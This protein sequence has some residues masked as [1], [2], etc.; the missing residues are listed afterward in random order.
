M[1]LDKLGSS[2]KETL[3]KIAKSMFVDESVVNELVKDIQRALLQADVN[4]KLV[5][6][7]SNSIKKRALEEKVPS[8]VTQKEY[9]VRIVYEELTKFMGG[10]KNEIVIDKTKKPFKIMMVG[11]FGSGKTTSISKI[12]RYY[13]N[14]GFKVATLGLDVHRPAAP[15]QLKQLSDRLNVT[16][17]I[18]EKEKNA[19]KIYK[20]YEKEFSKYD[21]LIIDTA[22]RDALSDDLIKELKELTNYAKPDE[23][24]LVI[25]SDLGQTA[26]K[27]AESFH[28]TCAV[29]GIFI[30]KLDGTAKGGGALSAC[31]ATQA[32][33]KFIGV[34]EKPE[35]I[36][37]FNPK[38]FVGRLL[39]MGDIEALLEKAQE[40]MDKETAEDL[41]K[42]L[43]KGEFNF[44]D[45][46]EQMSAMSKMGPLSKVMEMIPGMGG[47]KIPKEMLEG[48]EGKLKKWKIIMQS[49][50]KE[51][52]EDPEIIGRDRIERIAKGSGATV[53][54]VREL[55][56]QYKQTKKMMKMMKGTEDPEKLMKKFKGKMPK[57]F[58]F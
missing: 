8:G 58:K 25:S 2:L 10:E 5:F 47:M 44:L 39:G 6:A 43:L 38:G 9:L 28:E 31:A 16:C 48:Q 50:T 11:L 36:E 29:T 53:Q 15:Q 14:R 41:G 30:T 27:Q 56:K 4:V 42:R 22:G 46:Y 45:L 40:A 52:L 33:V 49:C 20:E 17:F 32:P 3:A 26:Q 23:K 34:G 57:G 19:L 13:T 35:D 54:E 51:E 18:N 12:G 1:V 24:L 37:V 7:L 21:L 55:L